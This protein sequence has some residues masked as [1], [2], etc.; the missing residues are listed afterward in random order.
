MKK[1]SLL[2][3]VLIFVAMTFSQA[4]KVTSDMDK[5][6]DFSKYKTYVF[7]GWQDESDKVLNDFDKKRLQ[8]SFKAEFDKRDLTLVE[9]GG[10]MAVSL[11]IV[12]NQK[13]STTAYSN[14]YGGG[15]GRG[16]YGGGWGWGNGSATTTY[17]EN[18]YLEGTL[19]IDVFDQESKQL[20]WQGVA[21][22]T[23]NENPKKREK[24]IPKAVNKLMWKFPISAPK[25]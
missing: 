5:N 1:I 18:D 24:N 9:E 8:D 13:T 3:A 7:L 25:K 21:T 22:K 11:F 6:A 10:D 12:I 15:M 4:Q 16:Y 23:I 19:V 17:S 20:I 2:S 14:Y